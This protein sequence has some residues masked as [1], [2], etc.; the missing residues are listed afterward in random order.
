M[1]MLAVELGGQE[2]VGVTL[3]P[4]CSDERLHLGVGS[5]GAGDRLAH[6]ASLDIVG[7]GLEPPF[8]SAWQVVGMVRAVGVAY[9]RCAVGAA[10]D[11]DKALGIVAKDCILALVS[12]F[13]D[14]QRRPCQRSLCLQL[15]LGN[16][17]HLSL[18][19]VTGER[20]AFSCKQEEGGYQ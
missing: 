4:L 20:C 13:D 11:D 14:I 9:H 8:Q 10:A 16:S 7:D 5:S 15:C 18:G 12:E 19:A 6:G 2:V 1:G 3:S 17:E